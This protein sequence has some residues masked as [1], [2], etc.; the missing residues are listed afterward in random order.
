[1]EAASDFVFGTANPEE[2]TMQNVADAAG[3]PHRTVARYFSSRRELINSIGLS[4]IHN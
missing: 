3:V 1:M 2:V 4:L